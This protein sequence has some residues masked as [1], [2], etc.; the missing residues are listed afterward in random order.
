MYNASH[1]AVVNSLP[2]NV[3]L[4]EFDGL[5]D[6]RL[7]SNVVDAAPNELAIG[8]E[9]VVTWEEGPKKQLLARFKLRKEK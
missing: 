7:V 1:E 2:Y 8:R 3:V 4:V 5:D 9:V 6:L